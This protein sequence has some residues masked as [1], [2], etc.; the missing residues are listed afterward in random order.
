MVDTAAVTGHA[1]QMNIGQALRDER[2]RRGIGQEKAGE[3]CG[4]RQQTYQRWETG[5]GRPGPENVI[6]VAKYLGLSQA[7]TRALIGSRLRRTLDDRVNALEAEVAELK[8]L[9]LQALGRHQP[10]AEQ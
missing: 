6:K 4:V 10:D 7:D 9:L 8:V 2:L 1:P 5:K 3:L